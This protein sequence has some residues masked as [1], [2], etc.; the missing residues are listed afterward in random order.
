MPIFMHY[1]SA[2]SQCGRLRILVCLP[3]VR[4]PKW[5]VRVLRATFCRVG[6]DWVDWP[7]SLKGNMTGRNWETFSSKKGPCVK[8]WQ[9]SADVGGGSGWGDGGGGG[10]RRLLAEDSVTSRRNGVREKIGLVWKRRVFF[11][12]LSFLFCRRS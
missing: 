4:C 12:S 3:P 7:D 2:Y 6:V 11:F 1:L 10:Q 5:C 8:N 9:W